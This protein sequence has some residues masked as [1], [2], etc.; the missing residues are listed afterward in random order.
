MGNKKNDGHAQNVLLW[1]SGVSLGLFFS[2]KCFMTHTGRRKKINKKSICLHLPNALRPAFPRVP[3]C[4]IMQVVS[5]LP[6]NNAWKYHWPG[7]NVCKPALGEVPNSRRRARAAFVFVGAAAAIISQRQLINGNTAQTREQRLITKQTPREPLMEGEV[8]V[9]RLLLE[10]RKALDAWRVRTWRNL[11]VSRRA[12][13]FTCRFWKAKL[14]GVFRLSG[15]TRCCARKVMNRHLVRRGATE[16]AWDSLG[17]SP[18]KNGLVFFLLL[19]VPKETLHL[20]VFGL[21]P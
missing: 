12:G 2:P 7:H 1:S 3:S 17:T 15:P 14:D 18:A 13:L 6:M 8:L 5:L 11:C 20:P 10:R 19:L 21:V 16:R 9:Y 4:C